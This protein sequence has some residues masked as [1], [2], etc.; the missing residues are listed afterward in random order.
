MCHVTAVH[1]V[2]VHSMSPA[3]WIQWRP[4]SPLRGCTQ[5][6]GTPLRSPQT[7]VQP[8]NSVQ[9]CPR[10]YA[11]CD[12]EHIYMVS[13]AKHPRAVRCFL[14]QFTTLIRITLLSFLDGNVRCTEVSLSA[15]LAV[16]FTSFCRRWGTKKERQMSLEHILCEQFGS[17][18]I[19]ST[20]N[21]IVHIAY[22]GGLLW[23]PSPCCSFAV[24]RHAAR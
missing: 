4:C 1:T 15:I 18:A 24:A 16:Q 12:D 10:A 14:L 19:C 5:H 6:A 11:V 8:H 20:L 3:R 13:G 21:G 22:S 17:P 9:L 23:S 2:G 7:W